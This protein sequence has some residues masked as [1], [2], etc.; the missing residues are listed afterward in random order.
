LQ[1]VA[2]GGLRMERDFAANPCEFA[3]KKLAKPVNRGLVVARRLDLHHALE[4]V[5]HGGLMLLAKVEQGGSAG[6]HGKDDDK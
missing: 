2:K 5:Q 4:K 6:K 3:G 1:V